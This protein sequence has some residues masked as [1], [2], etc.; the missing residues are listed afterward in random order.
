MGLDSVELVLAIE[1]E[2]G[3]DIPD[4]YAERM[5]TVGDVYEWLKHRLSTADPQACL[6]QQ[7]FYKLRRALIQ[8]YRLERH[9]ITPDTRLSDLLAMQSIE[10]GW[11]FLQMFIDLKTPPFQAAN[12]LLG[13]RLTE[14]TLTMRE[15]VHSLIKVNDE[16]FAPK[17]PSDKEIWD[18]LVRVFVRQQ[19]LRPEEVIL[20]ASI[21]KDLGVD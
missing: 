4:R 15:L 16:L 5:F 8:N 11:P 21:T 18:R 10:D 13:F 1:E 19:N 12:R 2:F 14:R 9:L 20:G 3:L 6:T 7:V 17:H